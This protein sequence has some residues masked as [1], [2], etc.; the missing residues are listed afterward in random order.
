MTT[1]VVYPSQTGSVTDY[2]IPF[3]YL[4]QDHVKVTL[5]GVAT[6]S[7][8]FLSASMIQM[9]SAPTGELRIYRETPTD[10][11]LVEWSSG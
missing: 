5:D 9:D 10:E 11:S 7:F 2:A 1:S 8:S 6:T 4:S 3:D